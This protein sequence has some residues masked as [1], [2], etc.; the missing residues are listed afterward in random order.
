ML[1]C[2]M[3]NSHLI[4]VNKYKKHENS[5]TNFALNITNLG[6]FLKSFQ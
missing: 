5:L 4:G 3:A 6:A 2:I 1:T